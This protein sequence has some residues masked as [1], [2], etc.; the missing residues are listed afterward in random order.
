VRRIE[1]DEA[2]SSTVIFHEFDQTHILVLIIL[3][4]SPL[5]CWIVEVCRGTSID[6][7]F[8]HLHGG[9]SVIQPSQRD[10]PP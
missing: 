3:V 9:Q 7:P 10:E 5:I 8:Q 4:L 6:I 1:R 2:F